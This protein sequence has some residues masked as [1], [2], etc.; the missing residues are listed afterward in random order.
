MLAQVKLAVQSEKNAYT[1]AED[2]SAY[3]HNQMRFVRGGEETSLAQAM[4]KYKEQIYK[5]AVVKGSG[6]R[7]KEYSVPYNGKTLTGSAL[8]EQIEKWVRQG[9]IEL[10][11][12]ASLLKVLA[13]PQWLDLSDQYFVLFGAA[14]AMGPFPLLMAMGA[15]VIA[16]DLDR[17]GIWKMLLEKTR[18][19]PGTL[20]FPVSEAAGSKSD[21]ELA[22]IAG[23]N[24]LT[25]TPEVRNWL[26]D[27][28]PEKRL[29]CGAY[30]YLDGPLFVKVS[31]AMD[32]IIKELVQKRKVKPAVAYL[33]TPTD[34]H[35]VPNAAMTASKANFAKQPLW[36]S[37]TALALGFSGKFRM[38][39]NFA[40]PEKGTD[41]SIC[42][43]V[44][45]DQGPN[46]ILAKRL[47]HWRAILSRRDGCI[48]STNIAPSTATVCHPALPLRTPTPNTEVCGVEQDVRSGLP[49]H[50]PLQ[51]C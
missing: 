13:N 23:C 31:V 30:A 26:L 11:C 6:E 12:G 10:S 32:A 43:A 33:C 4:D 1:I 48:A 50:A 16:L 35:V 28:H 24:L 17:E 19:S 15:N 3:L 49:G 39:K 34:A 2:G 7:V 29:V 41:L 47:Q 40:A 46:Y 8:A 18:A 36:Q 5:T 9:V 21:D 25:K 42:D 44:V 37:L 14:S 38:A 20:I 45:P 22:K 51:A 27:L